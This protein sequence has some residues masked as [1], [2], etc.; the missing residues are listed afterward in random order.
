MNNEAE[1]LE[2]IEQTGCEKITKLDLSRKDITE[3]PECVGQLTNLEQL[4]LGWN[5]IT[6]IPECVGQLI[7]LQQLYLRSNKIIEIPE[8]IGQLT[9]LEQLYLWGNKITKIPECIGQLTKLR[10]LSLKGNKITE[11]P[12]CIGQLINLEQLYLGE[13]E[14]T[15]IPECIGQ[16]TKLRQLYLKSNKITEITDC[17]RQL[18]KLQHLGLDDNPLNPVLI[19]VYQSGLQELKAYLKNIYCARVIDDSRLI[20]LLSDGKWQEAEQE[21]EDILL[22]ISGSEKGA[23]VAS[24]LRPCYTYTPESY[25]ITLENGIKCSVPHQHL[26]TMYD[27]WKKYSNDFSSF[28]EH[29]LKFFTALKTKLENIWKEDKKL[30]SNNFVDT[31]SLAYAEDQRNRLD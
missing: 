5:K 31:Y 13:N 27:L 21:T 2:I 14:I 29:N 12:E 24:I 26:H 11:I 10:G 19:N 20:K 3:I 30:K 22:K 4:Y 1:L 25:G 7:N 6:K 23:D 8:C 18:T 9:N 16:L 15:E 17:I 28:D